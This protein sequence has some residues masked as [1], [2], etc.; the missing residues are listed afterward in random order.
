MRNNALAVAG[1]IGIIDTAARIGHPHV[2]A[3]PCDI[4]FIGSN[5]RKGSQNPLAHFD[6]LDVQDDVVV[7]IDSKPHSRV[8]LG[9]PPTDWFLGAFSKIRNRHA[10]FG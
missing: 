3:F 9:R 4:E 7:R 6:F 10:Q 8:R 1:A 5:L 2:D